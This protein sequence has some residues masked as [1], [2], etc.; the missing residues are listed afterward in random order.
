MW[1][2]KA[3]KKVIVWAKVWGIL[4]NKIANKKV[5]V[6]AKVRRQIEGKDC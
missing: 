4:R 1:D 6:C 2:K 3:D 5:I